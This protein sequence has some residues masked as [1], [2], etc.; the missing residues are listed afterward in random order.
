[1]IITLNAFNRLPDIGT[2]SFYLCMILAQTHHPAEVFIQDLH[3]VMNQFVDGQLILWEHRGEK[4][5]EDG[6]AEV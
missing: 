5:P 2:K 3:K 1:M 4:R 6:G